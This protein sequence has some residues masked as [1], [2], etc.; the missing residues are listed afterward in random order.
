MAYIATCE[1]KVLRI[2]RE[3]RRGAC[4]GEL[5]IP[6]PIR[7]QLVAEG[8]LVEAAAPAKP[9]PKRRRKEQSE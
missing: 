1:I 5:E 7:L 8:V 4:I 9:E 2:G 3:W 6:E